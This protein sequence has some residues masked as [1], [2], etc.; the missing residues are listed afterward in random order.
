MKQTRQ[1]TRAD[2]QSIYL[3]V[4]TTSARS[5]WSGYMFLDLYALS[6]LLFLDIYGFTTVLLGQNQHL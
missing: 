5:C 3:D 4:Y 1:P 2:K 6:N